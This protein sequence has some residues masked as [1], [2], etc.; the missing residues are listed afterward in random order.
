MTAMAP[1]A[2][3]DHAPILKTAL[4]LA[5]ILR[6][7]AGEFEES[8][9]EGCVDAEDV[10]RAV[11]LCDYFKGH[12]MAVH[13]CLMQSAEDKR[14]DA[15]LAWM[16]RKCLSE[17][18]PRDI[19]RA[20]VAGINKASDARNLMEAAADRGYGNFENTGVQKRSAIFIINRG[21]KNASA[22]QKGAQA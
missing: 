6:W 13:G 1:I 4:R 5:R 21:P 15:L 22:N 7:A 19:V 12:A 18:R 17:V 3:P 11:L 20:N 14:V 9:G 16:E 8:W 10:R 2:N